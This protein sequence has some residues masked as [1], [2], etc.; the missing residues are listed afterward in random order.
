MARQARQSCRQCQ[1]LQAHV[2]ALQARVDA[3]LDEVSQLR[4]QL[5][6]AKKNSSTSSK[7]PSSD[8]IKPPPAD[9]S[10][11]PR[12]AG[13]QPGHPKHER[14]PF[15]PEQVTHFEEHLLQVC[16]CCGGGLRQNGPLA[17]IVQQVDIAKPPLTIEQHTSPEYWCVSCQQTYKALLPSAIEKGGLIGP[18]LTALIAYLKGV[19]HA[20]YS[21]VRLFLRDVV[22][23]NISRGQLAKVIAKVS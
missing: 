16:P 3:L 15:P 9:D 13:G 14:E 19:C 6:A 11:S 20:S 10:P 21:T 23:V 18:Q 12:R 5:A 2:D 4:E 1:R 7:P 8:I 17:R 22:G